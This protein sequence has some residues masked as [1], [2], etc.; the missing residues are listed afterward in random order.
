VLLGRTSGREVQDKLI[1]FF[2]IFEAFVSSWLYL[3]HSFTAR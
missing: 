3:R 1:L 2:V